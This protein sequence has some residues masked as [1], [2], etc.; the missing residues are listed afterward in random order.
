MNTAS[1]VGSSDESK[2]P[3]AILWGGLI[4]GT[5][6]L[7][8]A[9][10]N[11]VLRGRSL[12]GVPQSIASGLLGADAFKGGFPTAALGVVLHFFIATVATAVYYAASRK[13]KFLVD[14][15]VV[16]GLLYG[17]GVYL[18]MNFIVLPLSAVPFKITYTPAVFATGVTIIMLCVG[19]PIALV[20][21]RHRGATFKSRAETTP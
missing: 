5:L 7:A 10:V 18:F 16:S 20:I 15:A 2:A 9:C 4:A 3:R 12:I 8:A 14:Q 11:N 13:L 1:A 6:D 19:L 17:V 21:R